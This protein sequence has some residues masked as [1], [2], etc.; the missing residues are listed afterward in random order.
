MSQAL[1]NSAG[2]LPSCRRGRL[3]SVLKK[4]KP[5]RW[6][7]RSTRDVWADL[8]L[9]LLT[10]VGYIPWHFIRNF[11][12]RRA[13]VK[14]ASTSSLHWRA[15]FFAPEGLV[16]GEHCTLGNDGFYD[17]RSGITIGDCVN[18]AAEVR[19]YTKEHDIDSPDFA[20][21]GGPVVIEDYAYIG[22]RVTILPGLKIGK[23]AVV[24]SGAV[25]TKDV[26]PYMLVG[27]VPAKV[28]RERSHDLRYKLGYAK[29]FQ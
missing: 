1:A 2:K 22:T 9:Y 19:I 8:R 27:G 17:G 21:R 20:E 12:Y 11:W 7:V 4:F 13:G 24:A 15:R 16:I 25:V 14:L 29:R 28:I 3:R 26:P 23:G 18:I 5:L 10:N 6:L